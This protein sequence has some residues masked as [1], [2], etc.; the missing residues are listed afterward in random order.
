MKVSIS[1]FGPPTIR[2]EISLEDDISLVDR[3]KILDWLLFSDDSG[4]CKQFRQEVREA[5]KA[6]EE[7]DS[8]P[9]YPP[10]PQF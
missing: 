6:Y 8:E 1:T 3:R 7:V 5:L 10:R 2:A 4:E 9:D